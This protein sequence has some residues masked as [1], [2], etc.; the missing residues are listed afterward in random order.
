MFAEPYQDDYR[1]YYYEPGDTY[2]YFVRDDRYGYAYGDNGGLLAV[3]DATGAL[4]PNSQL[5]A[6]ADIA[7]RYLYRGQSLRDVYYDAPH[8][9]VAESVWIDRAPV[10]YAYQE[11]WIEVAQAQPVWRQ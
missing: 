2:P 6:L 10:L 8:Y 3:L 11:P 7:G 5:S 9:A 1:F 4:L